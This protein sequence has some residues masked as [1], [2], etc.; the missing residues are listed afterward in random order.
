MPIVS[1]TRL[2][3]TVLLL[4][5]LL[6]PQAFADTLRGAP[7]LRRFQ[8]E[9][10]NAAP[11][12]QALATDPSGRMYVGNVEGVLRYDGETWD[13]LPLPATTRVSDLATGRDGQIYVAS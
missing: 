8:P 1:V 9:D 11:Q 4:A 2:L 5:C 13:L 10:Y 3:T 7:L 6:L 12:H